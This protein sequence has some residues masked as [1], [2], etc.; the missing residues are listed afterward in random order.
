MNQRELRLLVTQN[1]NYNC[2][3]CHKEGQLKLSKELLNSE[4]Y[5]YL[6]KTYK[7]KF[8]CN[9]VTIT[10]GEP[11]LH[12]DIINIAEK[13]YHNGAEITVV[14]NGFFLYDKILIGNY[15]K[16]LNISFHTTDSIQYSKIV[17]KAD[18]LHK[19]ILGLKWFRKMYPEVEICFNVAVIERINDTEENFMK[20]VAFAEKLGCNVKAIQLFPDVYEGYVD[21]AKIRKIIC[22]NGYTKIKSVTRKESYSNGKNIVSLTKIFCAVAKDCRDVGEYCNSYNDLFVSCD[23]QVAYCRE[24]DNSIDLLEEV[25]SQDDIGLL[26]KIIHIH[27][28]LGTDCPYEKLTE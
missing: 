19:V 2:G 14:T 7:E 1:C 5:G 9:T 8:S 16:K 25:K 22:K 27:S 18:Q 11:L 26:N 13:L 17:G 10:G 4:D 15:I 24:K 21:I 12:R 23:G 3:F 6:F 28:L 20:I